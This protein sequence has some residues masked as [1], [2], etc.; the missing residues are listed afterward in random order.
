MKSNTTT[1][2]IA[3]YVKQMQQ[4]DIKVNKDYQ[5]SNVVWPVAARSYLI[6]TI[7]KGYPVPKLSL[8]QKTEL[9]TRVTIKEIVDGQQRSQAV[10]DFFEGKFRISGHSTFTGRLF[11][12]LE[13]EDQTA[14]ISYPLSADVFAAATDSEVR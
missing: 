1:F 7:L 10:R 2:T 11:E 13:P 14:F 12:Q 8:Y 9:K 5:R 3:E 4:G 6:D